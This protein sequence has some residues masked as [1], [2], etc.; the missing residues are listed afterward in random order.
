MYQSRLYKDLY[1][2]HRDA[3]YRALTFIER[4]GGPA[5]SGDTKEALMSQRD[6]ARDWLFAQTAPQRLLREYE[7][8]AKNWSPV[9]P[10]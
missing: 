4:Q 5:V 9:F 3:M 2:D 6:L 1:L 8:F 7:Q 10:D